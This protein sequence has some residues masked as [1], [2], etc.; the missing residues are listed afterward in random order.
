MEGVKE[1]AIVLGCIFIF[2]EQQNIE[3]QHNEHRVTPK[4][5]QDESKRT[6]AAKHQPL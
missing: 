5:S 2:L 6:Q 4:R 1:I 3:Q